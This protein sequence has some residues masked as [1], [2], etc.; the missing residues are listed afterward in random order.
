MFECCSFNLIVLN[1]S[2][3]NQRTDMLEIDLQLTRDNKVVIS[4]DNNLKRV[5]GHDVFTSDLMYKVRSI[6][7]WCNC[8]K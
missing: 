8:Y 7:S 6:C 2:A 1:C 4:H 3:A 5:T